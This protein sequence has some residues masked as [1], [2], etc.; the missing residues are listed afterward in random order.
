[1]KRFIVC[2]ISLGVSSSFHAREISWNWNKINT[3]DIFFPPQFLWGCADSALQTEGIQTVDDKSVETSWTL[4]EKAQG[5]TEQVGNACERWDRYKDDIGL[6]KNVGMGAY[7]FSIEW[8]KIEPHEGHFDRKAMQHYI[9]E[10]DELLAQG[11]V[12]FLTLFHHSAPVWFM[13]KKG[14][15]KSENNAYFIRYGLYVFRHLQ[16]KVKYWILFNEPIAYAFEGYFR[17]KY[18]P[19]KKSLALAGKVTKH[20]LNA[21]VGLAW[22]MKQINASVQIGIAHM[23]HPIDSYGKW[24]PLEKIVT[25]MFSHLMND[26]T[27]RFFKT[28]KFRWMPAWIRGYN[29]RAKKALDFIGVN[30]YTHTTIKQSGLKLKAAVR[31]DDIII[32]KSDEAERCKVMYAEGL[33]RSIKKAA[34]L[35]IPIFIT[36]NGV[37]SSDPEVK[38]E[39]LKRHLYVISKALKE[40][41]DIRGYFFWTLIDCF[42]WNKGFKNKHG[43]YAVNF[44]TQERTLRDSCDYLLN[45]I[46]KFSVPAV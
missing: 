11:I 21:H 45:T 14:F 4:Y 24:N 23:M 40:G 39:Y 38:Q 3:E 42:S 20:Q 41:F 33:Y 17:G 43:I 6:L 44:E 1:M 31:P 32:D 2:A 7:R 37:A 13:N 46:S 9:D 35:K 34:K 22:Q 5:Y 28:G 8:A 12:P 27:I 30:Y 29:E 10:V 19:G 18:P 36:E 26:S 25:K 15:E 16:E